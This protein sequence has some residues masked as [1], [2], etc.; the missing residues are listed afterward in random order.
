[1]CFHRRQG[2]KVG[3]KSENNLHKDKNSKTGYVTKLPHSNTF[4]NLMMLITHRIRL[5]KLKLYIKVLH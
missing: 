3:A 5:L 4:C 2:R 1:M